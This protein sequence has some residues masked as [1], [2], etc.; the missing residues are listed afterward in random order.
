MENAGLC[1]ERQ[2]EE[3]RSNRSLRL[4]YSLDRSQVLDV[5][6]CDN[7]RRK[8]LRS[9]PCESHHEENFE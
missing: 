6:A 9:E 3:K 8:F 5:A 1:E 2:E 4:T 7:Y